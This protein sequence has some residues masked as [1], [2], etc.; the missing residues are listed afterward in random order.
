[1]AP[2][3]CA[4]YGMPLDM[5]GISQPPDDCIDELNERFREHAI[6]SSSTSVATTSATE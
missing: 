5:V 3:M 2:G 4:K 6:G 1:M